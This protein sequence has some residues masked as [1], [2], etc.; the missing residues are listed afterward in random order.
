LSLRPPTDEYKKKVGESVKRYATEEALKE[1]E[2]NKVDSTIR[3][4]MN[5][6]F[7]DQADAK[8]IVIRGQLRGHKT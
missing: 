2:G 3:P 7:H 8:W 1:Q 4:L 6:E 5:G